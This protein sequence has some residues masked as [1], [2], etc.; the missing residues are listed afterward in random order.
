MAVH[1]TC[2]HCQSEMGTLSQTVESVDLGIDVLDTDH[3]AEVL[4]YGDNG[5]IHVRAI[6]EHCHEALTRN[7]ALYELDSFIQ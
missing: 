2:K 3:R 7:P 6:C 5:D 1:Y 4:T